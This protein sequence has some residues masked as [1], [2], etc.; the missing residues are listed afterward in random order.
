MLNIIS[1][2]IITPKLNKFENLDQTVIYSYSVLHV[3]S[4]LITKN[5]SF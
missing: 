5:S 1:H 3:F 4:Q 2:V